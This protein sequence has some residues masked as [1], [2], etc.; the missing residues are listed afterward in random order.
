M[1]INDKF[2]GVLKKNDVNRDMVA[3]PTPQ[4]D[5]INDVRIGIRVVDDTTLIVMVHIKNRDFQYDR[6]IVLRAVYRYGNLQDF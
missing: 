1:S 4:E 5:S 2:L 6:H 3:D